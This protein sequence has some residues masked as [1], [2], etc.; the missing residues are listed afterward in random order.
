[1]NEITRRFEE[2]KAGGL[3]PSPK[4]VAL[5]VL[6]VSA[7]PDAS[8]HDITRLIKVDPAMA[9]RVLRYANSA[10]T[11]RHQPIISLSQATTF[12][13]LSRVRQIALGF[14]LIDQYRKGACAAFDYEGYWAC[15]LATGIAAQHLAPLAHSPPDESFTCGLLSGIG[16]LAFATVFPDQYA[17]LIEEGACGA[18]LAN[19]ERV[20]FG[21]DHAELSAEMLIHWGLP[22]VIA[23]AVRH[24]ED[25][26]EATFVPG[27]RAHALS[28]VLHM[29]MKVG[30]FLDHDEV[31]RWQ[32]LPSLFAAGTRIGMEKK[33]V[34]LLVEAVVANWQG[35]A[36][37]LQ[38][39]SRGPLDM[40]ALL[41]MPPADDAAPAA[42]AGG[43]DGA[44]SG[45]LSRGSY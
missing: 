22:E 43:A 26:D 15:S 41:S 31:Q 11:G 35:W 45:Q 20:R 8:V 33:D 18:T 25:P 24:H 12:L 29:A 14:S 39:P 44:P 6:D 34:P 32:R 23:N 27:S 3:L 38:L 21:I 16:R 4:G 30:E 17:N 7:R 19:E 10:H 40:H 2:L 28:G 1:M 5:A 9:G 42:L 36:R 13:G 37:D